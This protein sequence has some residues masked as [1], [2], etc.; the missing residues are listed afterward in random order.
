ISGQLRN[1]VVTEFTSALGELKIPVLDLASNYRQLSQTIE[2]ALDPHFNDYGLDLTR[3][4]IENISVPPEVEAAIDK[5]SSMGAV[6]VR[7]YATFQAANAMEASAANPSGGG[8]P[9]AD[10]A[11][12]MAGMAMGQKMMQNFGDNAAGSE[13]AV[14]PPAAEGKS[15]AARLK[16]LK[17]LHDAGILTDDEWAQKKAELVK[18]L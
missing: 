12:M 6:G 11:Q 10:M 14:V 8:S 3:F 7:D 1:M 13:S 9:A 17:E 15:V 2:K 18:L 16:E 5:R 4:L